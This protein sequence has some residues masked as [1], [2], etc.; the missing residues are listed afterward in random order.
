LGPV[1]SDDERGTLNFL[2]TSIIARA[3][4]L[5]RTGMCVSMARPVDT[6]ASA[7]NPN[8]AIH[9]MTR[10]YA[11]IGENEGDVKFVADYL[12]CGCHGCAHSHFDALCHIAYKG[13]MYN[14]KP[15]DLV[16]SQCAKSM[17]ISVQ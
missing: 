15:V 13:K 14:N 6:I 7:D 16:S 2:T 9:H 5:I 17:D 1:G 12:G 11:I 3:S 4:S 10:G 8:P